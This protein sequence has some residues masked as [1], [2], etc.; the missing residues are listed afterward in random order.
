[1]LSR[2]PEHIRS[3]VRMKDQAVFDY[4]SRMYCSS[5]CMAK[6]TRDLS[7]PSGVSKPMFCHLS[8]ILNSDLNDLKLNIY[9][10]HHSILNILALEH[11]SF[12]RL[13][14]LSNLR[15]P[16]MP[17]TSPSSIAFII[18]H[19]LDRSCSLQHYIRSERLQPIN[20]YPSSPQA[21]SPLT[22]PW[23]Y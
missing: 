9:E 23:A 19:L 3:G 18:Q 5:D 7:L 17:T 14:A 12:P 8:T 11:Q 15:R 10:S 21:H 1:M 16:S 13:T 2:E 6:E 22:S 20:R 4:R